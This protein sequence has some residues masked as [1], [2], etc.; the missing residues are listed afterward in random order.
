MEGNLEMNKTIVFIATGNW[1]DLAS[2]HWETSLEKC[3]NKEKDPDW[4]D[5]FYHNHNNVW[6][7]FTLINLWYK[8]MIRS[9]ENTHECLLLRILI[10]NG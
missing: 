2:V 8:K 5:I 1:K 7:W 10:T 6:D 3:Q 9:I 4:W